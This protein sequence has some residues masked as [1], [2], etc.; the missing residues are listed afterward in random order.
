MSTRCR[1]SHHVLTR[2]LRRN[3]SITI[4]HANRRI[5]RAISIG[6]HRRPQHGRTAR[7]ISSRIRNR[8]VARFTNSRMRM[9]RRGARYRYMRRL[10]RIR[11]R[12]TGRRYKRRSHN[13]FTMFTHTTS[14]FLTRSPFF[15]RQSRGRRR[16]RIPRIRLR[17]RVTRQVTNFTSKRRDHRRVT[18]RATPVR[19]QRTRSGRFRRL[20]QLRIRLTYFGSQQFTRSRCHRQRNRRV[21]ENVQYRVRHPVQRVHNVRCLVRRTKGRHYGHVPSRRRRTRT[22]TSTKRRTFRTPR[23]RFMKVNL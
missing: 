3:H 20:T 22:Y 9:A 14:R 5:R 13:F 17:N 7:R 16:R 8:Q 2:P 11:I 4:F 6:I 19:R 10:R 23:P 12:R 21:R 15:R 18:S 1:R